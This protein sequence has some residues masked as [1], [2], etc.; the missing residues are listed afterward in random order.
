MTVYE[1]FYKNDDHLMIKA[2][3]DYLSSDISCD[4]CQI[5]ELCK[6]NP[7]YAC[8]AIYKMWLEKEE[9]AE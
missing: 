3:S 7:D 9:G 6:Q 5:S 1:K 2:L 4:E 8:F